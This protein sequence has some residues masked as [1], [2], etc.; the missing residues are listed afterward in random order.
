MSRPFR[1]RRDAGRK[2][3]ARLAQYAGRTDVIALGLPRGGIPVAF[4]V[5]QALGA[6]LDAFLVR[7]LGLPG[8]EEQAIG[9]IASGGVRVL[10]E[11]L[12]RT[13]NVPASMIEL[14]EERERLE[15]RRRE[16]VYR[17]S[18]SAP[19]V[20]GRT[21][22]L[23]DD[24]LATGATMQ[25]AVAA[26]RQQQ[27]AWIVGAV[28]VASP[29]VCQEMATHV[30]EMVCVETPDHFYAVGLWYRE[31]GPTSDEEVCSLLRRAQETP[32]GQLFTYP[33]DQHFA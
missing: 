30:D 27:P 22:L 33:A 6:P 26:L 24:G 15:L 32:P 14:I 19:D 4:E 2:L 10:N 28:P 25:A 11:E 7:K 17:G 31:F 16:R 9:A 18:R 13:L 8:H 29:D 5:A 3:A 1:N 20:S 21:V 12:V 23:I